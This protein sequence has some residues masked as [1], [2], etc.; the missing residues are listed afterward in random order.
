MNELKL[1]ILALGLFLIGVAHAQQYTFELNWQ[2]NKQL[3]FS[4]GTGKTIHGF[5]SEN[6]HYEPISQTVRYVKEIT[7]VGTQ[8]DEHRFDVS[9][10]Q[11]SAIS[12]QSLKGYDIEKIPDDIQLT[13]ENTKSRSLNGVYVSFSPIVKTISGF[14]KVRSIQLILHEQQHTKMLNLVPTITNSVMAQGEWFRFK[15]KES[16]VYKLDKS[17]FAS[18]GVDTNDV[19]PQKIRIFGNGGRSIPEINGQ[20]RY[21]DVQE[22]AVKVIGEADGRLDHSDYLLFY[23]QGAKGWNVVNKSHV[24]PYIDDTY[25]YVNIGDTNGKRIQSIVEPI[26]ESTVTIDKFHEYQYHEMDK[27]NV[28]RLGRKWFGESF[29]IE[30]TRQFTFDFSRR[31]AGTPLAIRLNAMSSATNQTSLSI[32]LND[33]MMYQHYFGALGPQSLGQEFY[34]NTMVNTPGSTIKADIKFNNNGNPSA[35]AHLDYIAL[36]A[37][38]RLEGN[39]K[40]FEFVNKEVSGWGGI[41][42]YQ[43]SNASN[44]SEV[45]DITDIHDVQAKT[46]NGSELLQFKAA[47]GSNKKYIAIDPSDYYLPHLVEGSRVSNQNLKGTIFNNESGTFEPID[48][49]LITPKEFYASAVRLAAIN[50]QQNGLRCKVV[51]LDDI[52]A[53][54]N[55]GNQDIGAIRNFIRYVYANGGSERLK[56]VCLFGDGSL[57]IRTKWQ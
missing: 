30:H 4:D 41:G 10:I 21:F 32:V 56:Y 1:R 36:E 49:L 24:N 2:Q 54:F 40:Q 22:T 15:I 53:E 50:K 25:Y 16:G 51:V 14:K 28:A 13:I 48:Y 42:T 33:Q 8:V 12:A 26:G 19:N 7:G 27:I 6:F 45:W 38:S 31:I 39:G 3:S 29:Q 46:N 9:N 11:Y 17:F 47:L 43:V 37:I 52:Y 44:I 18:L 34:H 35:I 57:I 23:A 20:V 5:Q 55:T